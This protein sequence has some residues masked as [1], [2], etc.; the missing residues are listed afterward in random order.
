[1]QVFGTVVPRP[2]HRVTLSAG[3]HDDLG[4]A[5]ME[6]DTAYD[7]ATVEGMARARQRFVDILGAAGVASHVSEEPPDLEPG[8]SVHFGGTLRMHDDPQLG[9]VDA[10]NRMHEVQNVVV[11]DSACFTTGPEKNPTVTAMALA[12]RAARRLADDLEG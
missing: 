6:I 2:E 12:C 3:E 7:S 5:K 8:S 11:A 10:W 1:V 4:L 9:V